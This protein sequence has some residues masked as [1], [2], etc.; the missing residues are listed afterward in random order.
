LIATTPA[1]ITGQGVAQHLGMIVGE[2][3]VVAGIMIEDKVPKA[4]TG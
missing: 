1:D 2:T 4:D 3:G